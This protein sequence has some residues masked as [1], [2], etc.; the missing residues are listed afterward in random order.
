MY[1]AELEDGAGV[2]EVEDGAVELE[3]YAAVLEDVDKAIDAVEEALHGASRVQPPQNKQ[4][5]LVDS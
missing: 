5:N 2:L 1:V 4:R 3:K